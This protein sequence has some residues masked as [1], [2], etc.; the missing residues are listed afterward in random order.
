MGTQQSSKLKC[1]LKNVYNC[2]VKK[3]IKIDVRISLEL[4]EAITVYIN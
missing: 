1:L 4:R 2:C 3:P